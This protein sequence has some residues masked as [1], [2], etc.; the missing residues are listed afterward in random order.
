MAGCRFENCDFVGADLTHANAT[1]AYFKNSSLTYSDLRHAYL[2]EAYFRD[3]DFMGTLLHNGNFWNA[4]LLGA[5]HLKKKNFQDP[6]DRKKSPATCALETNAL[7]AAESYRLLKHYFH[8]NGLYED[9][10]WAA[11]RELTMERKY[12][13]KTRNPRYLPSFL[14]NL[15]SGYTEMPHR[16]IL[17]SVG[18]IFLFS[19]AYYALGAPIFLTEGSHRTMGFWDSLYFS[20][21]TFTTVG[22]G[23][24]VPRPDIWFRAAACLEAFSGPFMAGLY[25]F[26]LTRRYATN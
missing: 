9:A 1:K 14:M 6:D 18:M 17:S 16:V 3:V 25:I 20:F 24:M 21:I 26:S 4:D 22:Y 23:D 5:K 11:Y 10:G 15:L 8:R 2:V 7:V 19:I 13:F 12:F